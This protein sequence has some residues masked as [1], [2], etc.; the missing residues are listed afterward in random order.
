MDK[1]QTRQLLE[2]YLNGTCTP[3]EKALL[4]RFYMD[5]S[6]QREIPFNFIDFVH[7]KTE[8][9]ENVQKT[10]AVPGK[11]TKLRAARVWIA[12]AAS[13]LIVLEAG[14]YFYKSQQHIQQIAHN[15]SNLNHISIGSNKAVLTLADDSKILLNDVK[16]GQLAQQGNSK[17][18]KSK[19]GLLTYNKTRSY[20]GQNS[21]PIYNTITVPK[22]GQYQLIL[23]DG[24]KVWLNSASSLKFPIAFTGKERGVEL[25]GEAYFEVAK[26]KNM[27]FNVAVNKT[28]VQVLGTHFNINA[29]ADEGAVK[30]TLLEGRV[31]VSNETAT[32]ILNPGQQSIIQSVSSSIIV[33][34]VDAEGAVAWKNG[35]L[36]FNKED[37]E[38]IMR[39]ISRWYN[40]DVVY[41]G[42]I[43]KKVFAGSISRANSI[44][45]VLEMLELTGSVHFKINGRRI[46]VMP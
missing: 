4:E 41:Q 40:V 12:A 28:N 17:V 1:E 6:S 36:E 29:Y 39:K 31:K 35:Y 43:N 14:F 32:A 21:T 37:I 18:N 34:N 23:S 26:D 38:S 10:I 20:T 19:D 45:D 46:T 42:N 9:W 7:S 25:S 16:N 24:T 15:K 22:G 3:H 44:S 27:P 33:K 8:I 30:T 13:I 5:E 2:K 11:V